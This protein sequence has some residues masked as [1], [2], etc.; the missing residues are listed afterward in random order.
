MNKVLFFFCNLISVLGIG[1]LFTTTIFNKVFPMLGR[2]AFQSAMAGGYSPED[3][4]MDF[5]V[6]NLLW[7][8]ILHLPKRKYND[9]D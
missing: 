7:S 6:I 3:Y 5:K 4:I 2:V 8:R 1:I 9:K